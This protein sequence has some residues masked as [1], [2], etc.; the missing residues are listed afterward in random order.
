MKLSTHV[1]SEVL[2][3]TI[4]IFWPNQPKKHL[5]EIIQNAKNLTFGSGTANTAPSTQYCPCPP[6]TAPAHPLRRGPLYFSDFLLLQA[7]HQSW[8]REQAA[9]NS[10]G[11]YHPPIYRRRKTKGHRQIS[12]LVVHAIFL[13]FL[14]YLYLTDTPYPLTCK[15]FFPAILFFF[16]KEN[17]RA[18]SHIVVIS[19]PERT[20]G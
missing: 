6:D 4:S 8:F 5:I 18:W 15:F 11:G 2:H 9:V 12:E 20:F 17:K 19:L 14:F 10:R 16:Q 7:N 13:R 1:L 3:R